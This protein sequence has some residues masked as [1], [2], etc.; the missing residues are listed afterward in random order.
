MN[1][2]IKPRKN[3]YI[4]YAII[5]ALFST[6]GMQISLLNINTEQIFKRLEY[7]SMLI[8]FIA[9]LKKSISGRGETDLLYSIIGCGI[10][11]LFLIIFSYKFSK[12]EIVS[13]TC[14]AILFGICR[15]IGVV[16][17]HKESWDYFLRNKYIVLLDI[18]YIAG[19]ILF[20]FGIFLLMGKMIIGYQKK[21][22]NFF[23]A[24]YE[25]MYD[26]K[27]IFFLCALIILVCWLPYYVS[28]W[29]GA[30]HGDFSMQ[31]LQLFH[32][33]TILQGQLTSD[34]IN[35]LYSN[36]HPFIHTQILGFF[37][38]IGI[39]LK[40]VSWGYGIYTFLQMSAYIIGIAL[41]LATLNKFAVDQ[42]ILKV[43]LFIY[44]LIPV[45][46][47]YSILVGG[48][49]FFSLMF[50]YFMI[51]VI[52][53]FGTKGKIFYN[54]KFNGIM[55]ITAFLLMA[56][57][58]QG[59]YVFCMFF[60]I[61]SATSMDLNNY[62]FVWL[63][64]GLK[65]PVE[66][67]EAFIANTYAY[68]APL[69]TTNRGLYLKLNSMKFYKKTRPWVKDTI[70]QTFI[71][72]NNCESP[73]RL[74][75]IR[76][77]VITFCKLTYHIPVINW[78]YN[79]GVITWLMFMAFFVFWTRKEYDSMITFIPLF[80]IFGICLLS[81]KNNNLRYIYPTCCMIPAMLAAAFGEK[82]PDL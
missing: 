36:D 7:R 18:W 78:L 41:L 16:F 77:T 73:R 47:L 30:I 53:I 14:L 45:F 39:R 40:H 23:K 56:A 65:H 31:V 69:L 22:K 63:K 64:M 70:P 1:I 80:L 72:K 9:I 43:V 37:I 50:L 27:H 26:F 10:F 61:S 76:K 15:W 28:L 52:W 24:K 74:K 57:K 25:K 48:D 60:I 68:Y 59:L 38:K 54:K 44:A 62:F 29:P 21:N 81:P 49:A 82:N 46:P 71:N 19:Y 34:G 2:L 13:A 3:R 79:P 33:P 75:K 55:I 5:I 17:S 11:L 20:A 58:N 51:E 12:R 4:I 35:I 32:Y 42:L 66:Y 6:I 8:H 67:I